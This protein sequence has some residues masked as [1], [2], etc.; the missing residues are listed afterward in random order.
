MSSDNGSDDPQRTD[1]SKSSPYP[2]IPGVDKTGKQ[3]ASEDLLYRGQRSTIV[4]GDVVKRAMNRYHKN[5][6]AVS[7]TPMGV[8]TSVLC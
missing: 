4:S 7:D 8:I 3:V 6:P 2:D 5:E 1:Y